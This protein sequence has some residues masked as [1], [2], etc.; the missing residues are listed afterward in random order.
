MKRKEP[1]AKQ[2]KI[3]RWDA[4]GSDHFHVS[5]TSAFEPGAACNSAKDTYTRLIDDR[6]RGCLAAHP[7]VATVS[8]PREAEGLSQGEARIGGYPLVSKDIHGQGTVCTVAL[9]GL[10][11]CIRHGRPVLVGDVAEVLVLLHDTQRVATWGY[12]LT[13]FRH[14]KATEERA[15][16]RSEE[17]HH[18]LGLTRLQIH[19]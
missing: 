2:P 13:L 5:G 16:T 14:A 6:F 4:E 17:L 1:A 9:L 7:C 18:Y 12:E 8:K 10:R 15:R 11:L 3:R 19:F